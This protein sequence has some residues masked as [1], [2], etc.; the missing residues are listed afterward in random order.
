MTPPHLC[1]ASPPAILPPPTSPALFGRQAQDGILCLPL[2]DC[3]SLPPCSSSSRG[4]A[5]FAVSSPQEPVWPS[6]TRFT[7]R[8][9]SFLCP[10]ILWKLCFA[11]SVCLLSQPILSFTEWGRSEG[12]ETNP[13]KERKQVASQTNSL[14]VHHSWRKGRP[15]K[16]T[17][18]DY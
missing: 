10:E 18:K 17:A 8:A 12:A 16:A 14:G 6:P 1:A 4:R 11:P 7:S 13:A 3:L 9:P 5:A 15:E 2:P